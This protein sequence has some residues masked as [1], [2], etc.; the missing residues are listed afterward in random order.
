MSLRVFL[1]RH[2]ET[3]WNRD[4][5]YQGWSDTPLSETGRAQAA[6]VA[7]ELAGVGLA[8]VYAS[9]LSRALDTGEAIARPLGL[10]VQPTPAF[11][12]MGFGSWEGQT[13]EAARALDPELYERWREAPHETVV[14][15]GEA[16]KD[17]RARVLAGL[18]ALREPHRGQAVCVVT[19][20][21][22]ARLLILEALGLGLDRIWSVHVSPTG[23]SELEFR[24]D[25][26]ALH[27]MNT[28]GH[29]DSVAAAR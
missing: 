2:A 6:A 26:T 14:P 3:A 29:L 12:E 5:R 8:A 18:A 19:H 24:D 23:V 11:K 13:L 7:K 17:V 10:T 1:V 28:L 9:P 4:R 25:W 20:A 15:G 27:R 16:L 22:V 21:I